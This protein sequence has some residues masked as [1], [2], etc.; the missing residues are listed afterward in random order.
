MSP[1]SRYHYTF[2]LISNQRDVFMANLINQLS[3]LKKIGTFVAFM[4]R[5]FKVGYLDFGIMC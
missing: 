3:N 5:M 4:V 1:K 2:L